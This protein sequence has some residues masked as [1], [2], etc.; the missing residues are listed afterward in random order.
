MP[1]LCRIESFWRL[2]GG[3][4]STLLERL[5]MPA[6]SLL[7]ASFL[8]I[9]AIAAKRR[10]AFAPSQSVVRRP[11]PVVKPPVTEPVLE[12]LVGEGRE[13]CVAGL[14]LLTP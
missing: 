2:G 13:Y 3:E 10:G 9:L 7:V 8:I 5:C 6:V 1:R 11:S 14:Y 12:R 4:A